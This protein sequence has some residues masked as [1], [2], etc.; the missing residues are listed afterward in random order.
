MSATNTSP[1]KTRVARTVVENRQARH[2]YSI[3]D[4]FTAGMI[5]EGWEVKS[6]LAGQA[7]FNGGAAYV[8]LI[9]GEAFIDTLT[10]TPLAATNKGLLT[11]R[12]PCRRRKLLLN[13]AELVKLSKKVAERGFTIVPL[14]LVNN[15]K[16]KLEIGLAKGKNQADKRATVKER[17]IKREMARSD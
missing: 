10:I 3:E 2:L 1:T 8:K 15:G 14:S 5:L 6:I 12:D 7:T 4:T 13:K 16:L 17:E 9:N 11:E